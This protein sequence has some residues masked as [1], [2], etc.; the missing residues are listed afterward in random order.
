MMNT[1]RC[2]SERRSRP[3]PHPLPE[4][5]LLDLLQRRGLLQPVMEAFLLMRCP[6]W[7]KVRHEIFEVVL[8]GAGSS[9]RRSISAS[10]RQTR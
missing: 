3:S 6:S 8:P 10:F 1:A 7:G 4:L 5:V 2:S 9:N